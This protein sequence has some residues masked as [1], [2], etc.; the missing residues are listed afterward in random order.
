MPSTIRYE[1]LSTADFL[2]QG[3]DKVI[4]PVGSCEAHGDHLPFGTDA[5]VAHDLALAVAARV[6]RTMVLPPTWFGMS[7]HYR[8]KPMSVSLSHDTTIAL[9]RDILR[10]VIGWGFRKVLAING[11]DGNIPCLQVAAQDVKLEHPDAAIAL[12]D[13]WWT[14]GLS[15]LPKGVW[16]THEGYGH[17]GE[18]ET[19]IALAMIPHLTDPTRARGMVDRKDTLIKEIWNYQELT[20][21]GATG[22]G[23]AAT[24]EKG[25]QMKAAIV[26]YIVSFIER[27]EREGW[28]IQRQPA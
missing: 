13:A 20:D 8:H 10:S 1:E 23:R 16:D 26:D 25:S 19:S 18:A 2:A 14:V 5:Y 17:G 11:H 22:D 24:A 15:L 3:F 7:H 9:F 28:V 4:V 27:K 6:E 12:V 21:E